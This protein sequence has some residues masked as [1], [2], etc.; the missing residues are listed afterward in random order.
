MPLNKLIIIFLMQKMGF[1]FC[2]LYKKGINKSTIL[3]SSGLKVTSKIPLTPNGKE[4]NTKLYKDINKS[5][6][7][8]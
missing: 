4:V 2:S 3:P 6:I 5:S 1:S 7:I 8:V